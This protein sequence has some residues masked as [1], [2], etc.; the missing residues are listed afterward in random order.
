MVSYDLVVHSRLGEIQIALL[1]ESGALV[2][3][4]IER[5]LERDGL[6]GDIVLARVRKTTAAPDAAFIDMAS[7]PPGFLNL[8]DTYPGRTDALGTPVQE[9]RAVVLQ[10]VRDSHGDK[11]PKMTARPNLRGRFA[12]LA[13]GRRDIEIPAA[14][15]DSQGRM[16]LRDAIEGLFADR[17]SRFGSDLGVRLRDEAAAAS[18]QDV[19]N[20]IRAL[21]ETWRGV[22]QDARRERTPR[23]LYRRASPFAEVFDGLAG[24]RV[25]RVVCD[26][27]PLCAVLERL[28]RAYFGGEEVS[29]EHHKGPS[30]LVEAFDLQ[31]RIEEAWARQVTLPC[32]ARLTI[33]ETAALTAIDVDTAR[34][35]R[36]GGETRHDHER[37]VNLQVAHEVA[38]QI[39]LRNLSGLIVV[40]MLKMRKKADRNAVRR[41][42]G[43]AFEKDPKK[44]QV[45]GFGPSGLL[46]LT[47]RRTRPP[48]SQV[49]Y[50]ACRTCTGTGRTPSAQT[51]AIAAV[52]AVHAHV[53]NAPGS[54]P[55]L[56]ARRDVVDVL[57]GR[58]LP[59]LRALEGRLGH[60]LELKPAE[61]DNGDGF[62]IEETHFKGDE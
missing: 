22:L 40:D 27:G 54:V 61:G 29:V 49:L 43:E 51:Q 19:L 48:L 7:G 16:R 30:S 23:G 28:C 52:N 26:D 37:H 20:D 58:Y 33:E 56:V 4:D 34:M 53:L 62:R 44:P 55:R 45:L 1:D 12:V 18:P 11:G 41:G 46:E 42:L 60:A 25:R 15:F 2:Q 17:D 8:G 57:Q 39:R 9:G 50:G 32:G 36:K 13:P 5:P 35:T 3:F 21:L 6:C 47:R 31:E 59:V 14:V 38:R 10:I 24:A